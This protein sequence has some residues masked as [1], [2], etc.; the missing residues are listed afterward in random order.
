MEMSRYVRCII[1]LWD[2][3]E[4]R[5]EWHDGVERLGSSWFYCLLVCSTC[6]IARRYEDDSGEWQGGSTGRVFLRAWLME[7]HEMEERARLI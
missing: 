1:W 6:G 3:V 7:M 5:E 4:L 2:D